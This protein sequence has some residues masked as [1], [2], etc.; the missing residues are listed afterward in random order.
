[1]QIVGTIRSFG[2]SI[3]VK[4]GTLLAKLQTGMGDK[5][6]MLDVIPSTP[7]TIE[8][9]HVFPNYFPFRLYIGTYRAAYACVYLTMDRKTTVKIMAHES[10]GGQ[11]SWTF[12]DLDDLELFEPFAFFM[13]VSNRDYRTQGNKVRYMVYYYFMLAE[14]L[15]LTGSPKLHIT[16][17]STVPGFLSACSS[18][19]KAG[20]RA[21]NIRDESSSEAL[22]A[23]NESLVVKLTLRSEIL[24][25]IT[26]IPLLTQ[27]D[28]I[29]DS[30][31]DEWNRNGETIP[32]G[33]ESHNN[34]DART[35]KVNAPSKP[36]FSHQ[37]ETVPEIAFSLQSSGHAGMLD[38]SPSRILSH[39]SGFVSTR[40]SPA[41]N[42]IM[43][44]REVPSGLVIPAN[45][46]DSQTSDHGI[47][48]QRAA[49]VLSIS[50][51][52][53]EMVVVP[54]IPLPPSPMPPNEAIDPQGRAHEPQDNSHI[55]DLCSDEDG[56]VVMASAKSEIE[57]TP[58]VGELLRT[59][60]EDFWIVDDD[61]LLMPAT[62]RKKRISHQTMSDGDDI[63][64]VDGDA[65]KKASRRRSQGTQL[66]PPD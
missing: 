48:Q 23:P 30:E 2:S 15:G 25:V 50:S 22:S 49:S 26:G 45:N 58:E 36:M 21:D 61:E 35:T 20:F 12:L 37:H 13:R 44:S 17:E 32:R 46:S 57:E 64:Q 39:D 63:M 11:R 7:V 9:Q 43:A 54:T 18:L 55:I 29:P 28:E 38:P 27:Y 33:K 62:M 66:M 42:E 51:G 34:R 16:V 53:D 24:S 60:R 56:S 4:P 1:V 31:D 52:V 59:H 3:E 41:T 8:R 47:P 10:N 14:N 19:K 65:W 5:F 6:Q 40:G